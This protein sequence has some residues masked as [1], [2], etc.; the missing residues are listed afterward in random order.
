MAGNVA[1]LPAPLISINTA[2]IEIAVNI[3]FIP[4]FPVK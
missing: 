1:A 4:E 2:E 3:L